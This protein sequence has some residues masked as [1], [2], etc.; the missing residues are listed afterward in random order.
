MTLDF[1]PMT[2]PFAASIAQWHYPDEYAFYDLDQD[3]EDREEFLNPATWNGRLFA[4]LDEQGDLVG[5]F[6]FERARDAVEIG[7][8][9]RP[10]LT[11]LG[12]GEAFV[13]AGLRFAR[14]RFGR[15][16]FRLSVAVFN[17]RAIRLYERVGFVAAGSFPQRTNGGTYEFVR[18]TKPAGS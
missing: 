5:F 10:D 11:G 15:S 13:R 2:T 16:T 18:M 8:G 4:V 9:L 6:S 17:R 12:H 14:R 3:P 1:T 7:L